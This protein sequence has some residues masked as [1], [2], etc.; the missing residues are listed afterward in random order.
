MEKKIQ[1]NKDDM[2]V[3]HRWKLV[4][5]SALLSKFKSKFAFIPYWQT[6][7]SLLYLYK[8]LAQYFLPSIRETPLKFIKR[9][10]S[11]SKKVYLV[12]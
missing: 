1:S 6:I 5:A 2:E 12:L 8:I 10:T 11:D 7:V 4:E 9:F 3:E